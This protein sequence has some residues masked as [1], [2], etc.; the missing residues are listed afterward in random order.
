MGCAALATL[1]S[2]CTAWLFSGVPMPSNERPVMRIETRQGV[3]AGVGTDA[4]ILMLARTASDGPCRVHYWLGPTP[5]V[6][7][8]EIV[9]WAGVFYRADIDLKHPHAEFIDRELT[10][11]DQLIA[12][13]P[14]V[15]RVD[16]LPLTRVSNAE[17]QGDVVAWPGRDLPVGTGVFVRQDDRWRLVGLIGGVL[18]LG[19]ERYY[20]HTGTSA[21]RDALLTAQPHPRPHKIKHRD[22]DVLVD[23]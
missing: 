8:G 17:V 15:G 16:E 4:G 14:E 23:R 10:P 3:E 6:E 22:D 2:S 5:L 9:P 11:S 12:L 7:D 19:G 21:L 1:S 18:E 13:V 20:V